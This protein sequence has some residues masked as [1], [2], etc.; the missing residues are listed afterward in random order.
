MP[1]FYRGVDAVL[2]SS[3]SESASLPVIEAAAAGRLVIGTPVGHFPRKAYEGGGIL[4]PIEP[5]KFIAFTADTLTYY[6]ENP[7]EY[8]AKCR[9][10]Q[11]AARNFDWQY[12]IQEWIDLIE[13]GARWVEATSS[14][15]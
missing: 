3:I 2:L 7:R 9:A 4:A 5:E 8:Q 6:K 12:S 1:E 13:A 10:I 14:T 15:C 11:K